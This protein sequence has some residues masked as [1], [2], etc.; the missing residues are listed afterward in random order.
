MIRVLCDTNVILSGLFSGGIPGPIYDA[1]TKH[2][3]FL[4]LRSPILVDELRRVLNS[5]IL[6]NVSS[7]RNL[8]LMA[9]STIL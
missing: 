5:L 9:C 7:E 2:R 4:F 8:M 1:R 3:K 6:Q